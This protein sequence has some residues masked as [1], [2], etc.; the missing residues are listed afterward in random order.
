MRINKFQ[1]I[2]NSGYIQARFVPDFQPQQNSFQM[3]SQFSRVIKTGEREREFTFQ[4]AAGGAA[5]SYKIGVR[6][7]HGQDH[8]F[9]M[10]QDASGN[11]RT[12]AQILPIWIHNAEDVLAEAINAELGNS[13]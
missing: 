12:S 8:Q 13:H 1:P 10:Y 11:W 7:D 2:K 6:G 5:S 4:S 9:T 3:S